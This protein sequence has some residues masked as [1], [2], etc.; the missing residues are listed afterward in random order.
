MWKSSYAKTGPDNLF[1]AFAVLYDSVPVPLRCEY[2]RPN[3]TQ[4][5]ISNSRKILHTYPVS[6]IKDLQGY[7]R[8]AGPEL[9]QCSQEE[10]FRPLIPVVAFNDPVL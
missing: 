5:E 4:F 6:L 3:Q 9:C 8:P 7:F 1:I 2:L 10:C